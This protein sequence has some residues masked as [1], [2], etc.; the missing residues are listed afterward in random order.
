MRRVARLQL[1]ALLR[2]ESSASSG[3]QKGDLYK[4]ELGY[5]PYVRETLGFA[6]YKFCA[7]EI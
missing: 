6:R 3:Q 4:G 7:L 1:C 5:V 2:G